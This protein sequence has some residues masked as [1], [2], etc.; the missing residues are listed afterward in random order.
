MD[1]REQIEQ[2]IKG[3]LSPAEA[4]QFAQRLTEDATLA[5]EVADYRSA[6]LAIA[7]TIREDL[8]RKTA[9]AF[10]QHKETTP[11]LTTVTRYLIAAGIASLLALGT[12]YF[13]DTSSPPS[14]EMLFADNFELP[15]TPALRSTDSVYDSFWSLALSAYRNQEYA[16]IVTPLNQLLSDSSF[17]QKD[18]ARLLLGTSLL[19]DGN[20]RAA[21][22]AL[23]AISDISALSQDAQWYL[24]LAHLANKDTA[25]SIAQLALITEDPQHYKYEEAVALL[26]VLQ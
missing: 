4:S 21:I 18:Q 5:K 20:A 2:Y 10:K 7:A 8:R 25:A 14:S 15:A 16:Q 24:A 3:E 17:L 11:K 23:A 9:A 6:Q 13:S 19:A 1:N 12:W 26:E 22:P